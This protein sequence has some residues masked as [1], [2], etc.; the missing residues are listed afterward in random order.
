M[1][2]KPKQKHRKKTDNQII[3]T[4]NAHDAMTEPEL[5]KALGYTASLISR[6]R[7]MVKKDK[8]R[9]VVIGNNTSCKYKF[10]TEYSGMRL[11]YIDKEH[12]EAWVQNHF[13]SDEEKRALNMRLKRDFK[14]E[15]A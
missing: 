8:I 10:F 9:Y 4:I 2:E 12:L 5:S 1:S 14:L 15:G 7:T 11:Y 13:M 3:K 6:L